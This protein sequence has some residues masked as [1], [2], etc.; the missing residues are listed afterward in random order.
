MIVSTCIFNNQLMMMGR[1]STRSIRISDVVASSL[2]NLAAIL[3][4]SVA[5]YTFAWFNSLILHNISEIRDKTIRKPINVIFL[6]I[7]SPIIVCSKVTPLFDERLRPLNN[8]QVYVALR[9]IGQHNRS[10]N[11]AIAAMIDL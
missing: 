6:G 1:L 5:S 9:F 4:L 11:R 2:A 8:R 3:R 10:V 7:L